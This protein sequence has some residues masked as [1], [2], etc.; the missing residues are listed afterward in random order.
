M[1]EGVALD[2]FVQVCK[3][4]MDNFISRCHVQ[5]QDLLECMNVDGIISV[6]I[7]DRIVEQIVPLIPWSIAKTEVHDIIRTQRNASM[8]CGS[9]HST[10][11]I[12]DPD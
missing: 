9:Q 7:V 4:G 3:S 10:I 11:C 5:C 8:R 1:I 12:M 2:M 6:R